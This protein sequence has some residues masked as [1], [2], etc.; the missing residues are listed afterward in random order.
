M[1]G[2]KNYVSDVCVEPGK[3]EACPKR[4]LLS[5]DVSG[6]LHPL[7][8][9]MQRTPE[10]F[11]VQNGDATPPVMDINGNTARVLACTWVPL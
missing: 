10:Q 7:S 11:A 3:V 8:V 1:R 5:E 9:C 4:F 6:A 2:T